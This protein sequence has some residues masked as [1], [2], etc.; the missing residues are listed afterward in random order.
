MN[1]NHKPEHLPFC[2]GSVAKATAC[3]GCR[4]VFLQLS[5]PL[6]EMIFQQSLTP[7]DQKFLAELL[8]AF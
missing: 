7:E 2:Q 1:M 4:S 8:I 6:P 3:P 5:Q